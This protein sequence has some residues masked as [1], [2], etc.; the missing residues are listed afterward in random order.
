MVNSMTKKRI[1]VSIEED[2]L[3]QA[4]KQI[5][6]MS[7]FFQNCLEAYL[8]TNTKTLFYVPDA[9]KAIDTIRD[10]QTALFLLTEREKIEEN[11]KK[12]N[13]D[14]IRIAWMKLYAEY[15]DTKTI[16]QDKLRYA[17]EILKVS[18]E[19]LVDIVEV[20]YAFSRRDEIDVT[21]WEK[22]YKEYGYGDD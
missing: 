13:E 2:I 4:K 6:N 21:D 16:N 9:Q 5:P 14:E 7:N 10:A 3:E 22:V 12:A 17:S 11:I 1:E 20:C 18:T 8:G 19:E 15:R